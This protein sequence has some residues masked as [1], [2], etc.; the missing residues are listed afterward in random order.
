MNASVRET[1]SGTRDSCHLAENLLPCRIFPIAVALIPSNRDNLCTASNILFSLVY[2][3]KN[4]RE[5]FLKIE[6]KTKELSKFVSNEYSDTRQRKITKKL[7]DGSISLVRE[8][9][10]GADKLRIETFNV[11]I[12]KLT[13]ELEKEVKHT[14]K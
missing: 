11:I 2:F 13:I 9:F 3:V 10:N 8:I 6:N 1:W 14:F 7:S 5:D 4:L 12:D